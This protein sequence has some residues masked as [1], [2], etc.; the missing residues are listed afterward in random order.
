MDRKRSVELLNK[1]VAEE[2][3]SV[4]QYMYYHFH[5]DDRGYEPLAAIFKRISI[6]EMIHVEKLAERILFLKG[7]VVMKL[8]GP[9]KPVKLENLK[10]VEE[11]L[12]VARGLE[13]ESVADYNKWANLAASYSD[14]GTKTLFEGI[15]KE[16]EA[17]Y[18]IFDT[19]LDNLT[20]FGDSYLSLQAID[21]SKAS[22]SSNS[23]SHG[24]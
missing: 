3:L 1:A 4:H 15:I 14:S 24:D 2:L 12:T 17:H 20:T 7:D 22:G 9:V 6:A 23:G 21:R 10:K 18:D 13:D 5:C 19:E 8:A 11:M 16:E